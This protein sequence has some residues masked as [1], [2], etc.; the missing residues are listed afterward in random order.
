VRRENNRQLS[1]A[2]VPVSVEAGRVSSQQAVQTIT[3]TF[4]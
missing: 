3:I 2:V 4:M 1:L